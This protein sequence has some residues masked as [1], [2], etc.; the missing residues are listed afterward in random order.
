MTRAIVPEIV[1]AAVQEARERN[2]DVADISLDDI[3]RRAGISR[4]TLYRRIGS[5][6]A[7]DEAVRA[8]G[9]DPGGRPDVRERAVVAAAAIVRER[10]FA[11]LTL[12]AVAARA[13]CSVPAL[14]SQLGGREGLLAA[15]FERY[16]PLP[17]VEELLAAPPASFADGVRAIVGAVLDAAEAEP[18]LLRAL[19]ADALGRP[20][21]PTARQVLTNYLPRAFGAANRWLAGEVAAGRIRPLPPAVLFQLLA[22]PLF[23]HMVARGFFPAMSGSAL[24]PRED[25]IE[26][27]SEAFCRAVELPAS[28]DGGTGVG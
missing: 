21:G 23:L 26:L 8:A 9:I 4:I 2:R 5:R 18:A 22:G 11:A 16:S 10:G 3:A 1:D 19:M 27:F 28:P 15:L 7:L 12:E 24:P 13:E 14:H 6:R 17:R 20:D 25:V